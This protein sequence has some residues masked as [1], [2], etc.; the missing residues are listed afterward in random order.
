MNHAE[1]DQILTGIE[2]DDTVQVRRRYDK[3][4]KVAILVYAENNFDAAP[5]GAKVWF[6]FALSKDVTEL[7]ED[8]LVEYV[9]GRYERIVLHHAQEKF[10]Y[11]GKRIYDPHANG[12]RGIVVDTS[13]LVDA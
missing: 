10:K 9:M 6:C 11:R 12:R 1:I 4:N 7:D 13:R 5:T 2:I 8:A 3:P